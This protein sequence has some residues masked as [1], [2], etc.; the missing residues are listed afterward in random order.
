ML[1]AAATTPRATVAQAAA[2]RPHPEELPLLDPLTKETEAIAVE[3]EALRQAVQIPK[4]PTRA[5]AKEVKTSNSVITPV[6]AERTPA[7]AVV[8]K[9]AI[10][11]AT[12]VAVAPTVA[13]AVV[14]IAT[15]RVALVAAVKVALT[16]AL[17]ALAVDHVADANWKLDKTKNEKTSPFT[18]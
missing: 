7:V 15:R 18:P 3:R 16:T 6:R 17:Q 4:A 5:V 14:A 1:D 13:Q 12:R 10:L 9:E 2:V 8:A 11:R